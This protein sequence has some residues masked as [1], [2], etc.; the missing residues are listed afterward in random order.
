MNNAFHPDAAGN[1]PAF[2]LHLGD[3][4]YGTRKDLLYRD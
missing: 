4:V 2:F 1:N 3:V